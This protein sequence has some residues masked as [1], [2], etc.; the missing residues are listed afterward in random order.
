MN[1]DERD[2]EIYKEAK[3]KVSAIK[4]F[5]IHLITYVC[6]NGFLVAVNLITSR[7][8]LWFYWPLLGWGAGLLA[9]GIGVFG[10]G[11]VLGK[12]WEE[13]KIREIVEK[14]ESQE[15]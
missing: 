9:H 11:G 15:K 7:H 10:F 14:A 5:Y 2:E 6:V 4:D 13:R 8:T 12:D 3:A 1:S